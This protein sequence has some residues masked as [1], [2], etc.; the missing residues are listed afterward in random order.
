M[1]ILGYLGAVIIGI[2]LGI[3]GGGGSIL[4]VPV[5][6]YLFDVSPVNATAYSLFAVGMTSFIGAVSFMKRKEVSYL[7]V[8]VFGIPAFI[9]V[10][11]TRRLLIPNIPE[12]LITISGF[13]LTKG[14][15]LLLIFA[16]LMIAAAISMIQDK[17]TE[18]DSDE[19]EYNY[20]MILIEGIVVGMLTG[21]VGAG[22][23][24]LII[25]ALVLLTKLPMKLAVG[26]SLLIISLK[27]LIGVLGDVGAD[28]TFD[29]TF[30]MIFSAI[31]V[32][33]IIIGSYLSK[34]IS[35]EKLK[36][37]FGYFVFAMGIF[38]I[39]KELFN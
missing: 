14:I 19:I 10:Y 6:V 35:G 27:S 21:L 28:L 38:I 16:F 11:I 9:S 26:T 39:V 29:W 30:L 2:S 4:T 15:F 20:P 13:V 3:F 33:G 37:A 34:Y 12:E 25:P 1:D 22:G 7:T 32:G 17:R 31:A 18:S 24:F 5:L 23:G 8:I 36:R